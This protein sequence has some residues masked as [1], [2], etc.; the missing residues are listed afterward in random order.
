MSSKVQL[1]VSYLSYEWRHL[2]NA[3]EGKAGMVYIRVDCSNKYL[4]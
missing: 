3:Y 4:L 1:H 2:V